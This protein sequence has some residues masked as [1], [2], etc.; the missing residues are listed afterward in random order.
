LRRILVTWLF[1]LIA[2]FVA[3]GILAGIDYGDS[4]WALV[5]AA[6]VFSLANIY[7]R[8]VLRVLAFPLII[9]TLGIALFLI[10]LLML[11]L[12]DWIVD[13]FEIETFWWGVLGAIIVSL[14]NALMHRVLPPDDRW[15]SR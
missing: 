1:N 14:V 4:E 10:N 6:L 8:P 9:V 11:Y 12:T 13:D 3:S 5:L 15:R 7:V 2:L